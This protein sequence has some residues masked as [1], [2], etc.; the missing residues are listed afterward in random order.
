MKVSAL[1]PKHTYILVVD[2]KLLLNI[3]MHSKTNKIAIKLTNL[4]IFT[5]LA[6]CEIIFDFFSLVLL[7]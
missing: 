7:V 6:D 5:F 1:N 3:T 4:P 2:K